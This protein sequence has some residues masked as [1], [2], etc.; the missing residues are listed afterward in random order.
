MFSF[1]YLVPLL[2]LSGKYNFPFNYFANLIILK[3][4]H[5]ILQ[6]RFVMRF[7]EFYSEIAVAIAFH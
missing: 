4:R 7:L 2:S 6:L 3:W 5:T 1:M